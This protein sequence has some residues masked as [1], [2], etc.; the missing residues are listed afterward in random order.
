MFKK[1]SFVFIIVVFKYLSCN[2]QCCGNEQIMM[3]QITAS[4]FHIYYLQYDGIPFFNEKWSDA[5]LKV[6]SGEIYEGLKV[7][8]DLFKDELVYYNPALHKQ[9]IIDKGII[10]EIY[11]KKAEGD[12][13]YLVK[14]ICRQDSTDRSDCS[15]YFIH[16]SDSISLWSTQRKDVVQYNSTSTKMLGYY[17]VQAKYYMV[18]EGNKKS[19]PLQKRQLAKLFPENKRT[20]I[21]YVNKNQLNLKDFND[22]ST[23]FK[24]I[25]EWEKANPSVYN[26]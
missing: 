4:A 2:A 14:N 12:H 17:F 19:I 3:Q 22:L 26:K 7:R 24:K 9:L 13:E 25:N 15:F 20:I 23:L 18:V 16:V 21:S 11:L 5:A 10:D 1:V 6:T 8:I